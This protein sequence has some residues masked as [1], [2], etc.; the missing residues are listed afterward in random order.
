MPVCRWHA[1]CSVPREP[2][3]RL[4][5]LFSARFHSANTDPRP[6]HAERM[7]QLVSLLQGWAQLAETR[8]HL[9][10]RRCARTHATA[11]LRGLSRVGWTFS[12][13]SFPDVFC[14]HCSCSTKRLLRRELWAFEE[15]MDVKQEQI[16]GKCY[17]IITVIVTITSPII[18]VSS[19]S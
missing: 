9:T 15:V 17:F 11:D 7:Q 12:E 13:D 14:G 1:G 3:Q 2:T 8:H 16:L 5:S 10:L 6:M 4:H 18:T 19:I